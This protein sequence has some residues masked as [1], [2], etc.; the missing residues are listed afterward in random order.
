MALLSKFSNWQ[1][2]NIKGKCG[3]TRDMPDNRIIRNFYNDIKDW[4]IY[5][6]V[7][8]LLGL[9][10]YI[11]VSVCVPL[12]KTADDLIFLLEK[13]SS[14]VKHSREIS[15]PGGF[16][17]KGESPEE[18]ARRELKEEVLIASE[19]I[20]KFLKLGILI[21]P[22]GYLIHIFISILNIS[23]ND[24]SV[25]NKK[26]VDNLILIPMKEIMMMKPEMYHVKLK[27]FPYDEL[28][29]GKKNW[30]LPVEKLKLGS[31]YLKPWG[32]K[33][34]RVIVYNYNGEPI[35]GITG[36]IIYEIVKMLKEGCLKLLN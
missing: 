1:E 10:K 17:E 11:P 15:F 7:E 12:I 13:R 21:S 9:E 34:Y 6:K 8:V 30:L 28:E 29:N 25:F 24:L 23:R 22:L 16:I 36:E 18:A 31:R 27:I 20:E 19:E 32:G 4:F 33:S 26:E 2:A 3:D 35:W 5:F 14:N